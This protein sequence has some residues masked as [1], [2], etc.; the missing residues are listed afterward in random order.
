MLTAC[1]YLLL[2][3]DFKTLGASYLYYKCELTKILRESIN[4]ESTEVINDDALDV[5]YVMAMSE[6]SPTILA[7]QSTNI[8][9]REPSP[10]LV[11][12][13]LSQASR[14]GNNE[15]ADAH[16][17]GMLAILQAR[18]KRENEKDQTGQM[19]LQNLL[20]YCVTPYS[21]YTYLLS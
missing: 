12:T 6:V 16:F 1:N 7:A 13:Y 2:T 18:K 15:A 5:A 9:I 14:I 8:A 21:P 3:N 19:L 11:L 10:G 4:D 17:R 20:L